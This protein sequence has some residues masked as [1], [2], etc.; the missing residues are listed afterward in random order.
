[1]RSKLVCVCL[2]VC[3]R[4]M[5]DSGGNTKTNDEGSKK[6]TKNDNE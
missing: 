2:Y 6:E 5:S 4:E 3:E 1:M